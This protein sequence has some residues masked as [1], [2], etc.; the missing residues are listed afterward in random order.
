MCVC[1]YL[2]G[3]L[4]SLFW[5]RLQL[6]FSDHTV[7]LVQYGCSAS[8]L[9]SRCCFG[10]TSKSNSQITQFHVFS[11]AAMLL[12][13]SPVVVL[14]PPPTQ[15][16]RSHSSTCSVWLQCFFSFLPLLFWAH[17][18]VKFSDHTVPRVQYGCNASFLFSR[19]C[20]GS[21]SKSNSQITQFHL[22]SM[23]AVLLFFSP[24]VVLG[25][26]PSQIL[27]SHSSTCSVWL[28]CFFSFLP[29]L[30]WFRLQ[31]KF[32]D[33]TVPLVQYGCSASF[34]FSRCCF[35][36][37]SKSNSQITQFHVFSMAAMLLF[38]SPVVVLGPPPSQILR[39]HSSTCSVW[40]QCFFSFLPLLFWAHLQVKFSDHT[41]PRVQYGCN[42]SFLF[43]RCCFGSASKSNSQITQFHLFSMAAVLLFFSPVVVLGPPPSQILRSHSST[44]SVWLQCFFSFLPLLFWAHLQ[45]KFSDHTVPLVQYGCSASFLFSRCC[46]GPTSKSNS[47]ITQFHVFSMAAMLL[48]FSPV[49]VLGPPPSQ[50]LRSHS[51]TCSVWLQCF[52]SFLP[53]LFWAHL[54]VKFSDHTVPLVQYGCSASFL[55]YRCCFG[56]ASNSNSQ[57]TQ[58]HLFSMA[59]VLLFFSTVVVLVPPPTQILRSHSSTCSVWLQCFF[60]FLPLLFWFRLQLKFSDHTVPLVQYGCS[61]SFLFS[62]CCFGPTSKSNSQITQFRVFSIAAMLL[63]FSPVVVLGPPPSQILRSHSSTCSV[64]LQCFFSFL[65]LLFWFR[66]QLKF[67]DH[68]VPLVQYG[69]SASFLFYRCCFGSASNSNSQITQFHLF[70]MAAVLLFFSTVVVLVPPPTQILRSHSS[71][72]SV[73]LQCFFSFL[74]LLFWAHLQVKFSDHTVPLVQYG[75][76]ASFLFY[77][78]CFGSASN[79]NSQI[80]QFHLFSMA[81]VLLFFSTVVVLVPPPTQILRSHSSTCSVWLQCFFSFLPLL[82]WFR[83]QLK[84]SDHTVPLVQYGCSASFLFSRCCFGPTSKSNSQIT[85]FHLFSMAAMLLFFSPVVVLGPPPSQ[86]LRSHSSTCSV[87]LQCFFSFL[88]LLFWAH[89]QVKFSDHTVPLVQY[90]C[91]ASFLFYRCC[92]G[93]TSKSNSQITQF[94]VFS[95][96]AMLLFFSPV[97]VLGP[98]PSQILRSHSSTCSVWLQ[99]FFSFLP[100]LFWF[101]LQLKF[102]DHTVPLVQYGCSASFLFSRCCFG[103]T[104]KSNSQITQF[105]LFSMAAMLLF[106]SPVVVLGPPPSQILRS[107]SSTCSVWLQ[108]FFS[109]LPLLFWAH[110]QVKFSDHTVPRVQ[111]CC[112]ASFLFSR[113]C[114]GPTSKSNSQITQFHLFSMAAMLLFFS[115]VVVLGPPP[116]Q[117]IRSHS[118]T[119]SVLLQ[120]FFSFLPLLFWAHLQVKFSDHTVPRVQYCRNASF[121]FSRCCFGP[122]SK[123]NS[124]ITQ[125]HLFSM[126]AM[127]LF[128]S[129]VVVLGPPPSQILRSH[130]SACSVLLQCFFSFLPLLFWAHLQVKFSDHTVPPVQYG[131]NASFLFSR[132]CFGPTSKSNYQI[133]QFHVFSIAAMLLFFSTVVVLGPPPS[134]ILR[135]HS[136]TCSVLPQC[137][138]SFLPSL[139][140][141]HLQVKFSDHT[142]PLVQYCCNASFLFSRCCFGP[143]SKS[144]YL[145]T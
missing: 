85:Q 106:F 23:A 9:F 93:P 123:S 138:F 57:I 92:F 72:C 43:S 77:R 59:A 40:L 120:C 70:S 28:Q 65:P 22:F 52:F 79:S 13:F 110:L 97:V 39:S 62:R 38:F 111:Y 64:W 81:A 137:F 94:H 114:F 128:F 101:R 63:F 61:A 30:F 107:H 69:C 135:S 18:Q 75:C 88:P 141:A 117:I 58:F 130:S 55:F 35:G 41:V 142:V 48:F 96:A 46:F 37:T 133:A 71:T 115:P 6:K 53:L 76:S 11:M 83:L 145:I 5:F 67:S 2:E 21:A 51:S 24:V 31:V 136:S 78:C 73:W 45:V 116:S 108:C 87:W 50:I 127:L 119:C 134:Q 12:F 86:I 74:P 144:N 132:C 124:Q 17:L 14:G 36:P 103:P 15:I 129:P 49:V 33:H 42:A 56:S 66:L 27:R 99:C 47:Q 139:F 121:L 95:M 8:F 10:P 131:C 125:F 26:P 19:C 68:T 100:L 89:L 126:A 104:S 90:G 16:L 118:S 29:L 3:V 7:P 102:S 113:C 84:F 80:T 25:P 91:S 32:S 44:C 143:T 122:T 4:P 20:F 112:N 1:V 82:F 140:W 109:F 54:Q 34:L 105:H 98:P 60:S